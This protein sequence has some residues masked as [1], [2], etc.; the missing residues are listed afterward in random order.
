MVMSGLSPDGELVEA[1]E[2]AETTPS[3]WACSFIRSSGRA[4]TVRIRCSAL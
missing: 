1:A 3:W 4:P 2:G